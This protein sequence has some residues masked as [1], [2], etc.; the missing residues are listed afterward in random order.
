[1]PALRFPKR[2][3]EG[4]PSALIDNNTHTYVILPPGN[5]LS[6]NYASPKHVYAIMIN[7][8]Y[9]DLREQWRF[10]ITEDGAS[11]Y[12]L[13]PNLTISNIYAAHYN[14]YLWIN[15]PI[16]G[17]K[18]TN[19][20]SYNTNISE[21]IVLTPD[22]TK[23]LLEVAYPSTIEVIDSGTT[24]LDFFSNLSNIS[25]GNDNT[26][27]TFTFRGGYSTYTLYLKGEFALP[28]ASVISPFALIEIDPQSSNIESVILQDYNSHGYFLWGP[29]DTISYTA[30]SSIALAGYPIAIF[31]SP[32]KL[33]SQ[34]VYEY[35]S[36]PN[37]ITGMFYDDHLAPINYNPI[38]RDY[39][40]GTAL[41]EA[42]RP[43]TTINRKTLYVPYFFS[44]GHRPI[45]IAEETYH[46]YHATVDRY[47]PFI[48][49]AAN[50]STNK[51]YL[52]FGLRIRTSSMVTSNFTVKIYGLG[53]LLFPQMDIEVPLLTS[54]SDYYGVWFNNVWFDLTPLRGV[55]R[56]NNETTESPD[57]TTD[58]KFVSIYPVAVDVSSGRAIRYRIRSTSGGTSTFNVDRYYGFHR[59]SDDSILWYYKRDSYSVGNT[60]QSFDV[61]GGDQMGQTKVI[62]V[63]ITPT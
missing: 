22:N 30:P 6:V 9:V 18:F 29:K 41:L 56:D 3:T 50:G 37:Y 52:K 1:M 21:I 57:I 59:A 19:N 23:P 28:M 4:L 17:W 13:M 42:L 49:V 27:A 25:D 7:G 60:L 20:S 63:E 43:E 31:N 12:R 51:I 24:H 8:E 14:P 5:T 47:E 15:K 34:K 38:T 58:E 16:K 39:R 53:F 40:N 36:S 26:Y 44:L 45:F 10:E 2:D 55:T 11:Y 54:V 61:T 62:K 48:Y 46:M 32:R 35:E 33:W